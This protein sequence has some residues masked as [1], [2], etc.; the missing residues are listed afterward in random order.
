MFKKFLGKTAG[1]AK[2][3]FKKIENRNLLE[4]ICAGAVLVMAADG[5]IEKSEQIAL[6]QIIRAND[7]VSHFGAEIQTTIQKFTD[8]VNAG[9]T[10]AKIK[11]MREI[12]DIKNVPL[13]A[14][15]AF[16]VMVD[17]AL[18]DGQIEDAEYKV[19]EN[20]ARTLG[21]RLEDFGVAA[22]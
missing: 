9:G 6:E 10:T 22:A 3:N 11:I 5:E 15:E 21:L 12:G 14:E 7:S 16:A 18:A 1:E 20:V 4:A 8:M 2:A 17:I 19:L 13:E